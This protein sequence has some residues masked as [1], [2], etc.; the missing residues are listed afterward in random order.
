MR[1]F[2]REHE[3]KETQIKCS[4][5]WEHIH[6]ELISDTRRDTYIQ[7]SYSQRHRT[8][9]MEDEYVNQLFRTLPSELCMQCASILG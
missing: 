7:V 2:E 9:L 3:D 6:R 5:N 1:N 8:A 4:E